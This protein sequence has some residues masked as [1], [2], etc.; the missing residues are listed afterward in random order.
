M[1]SALIFCVAIPC[2]FMAMLVRSLEET[3]PHYPNYRGTSVYNGLGVVWFMWL[4]SLWAGAHL[5]VVTGSIQ[6]NWMSYLLPIFPLIA[7]TCIFGLLDDWV[8]DQNAKGFRGHIGSLFRG[9]L[10]TGGTKLLAIGFLSLFTMI[11]LYWGSWEHL[12]S[13]WA[14]IL[15]RITLGT[16]V[17]ALMANT[18]NL[19]DLRP[20]R[21]GKVYALSLVLC[22]LAVGL[23][24]II[25]LDWPDIVALA[26]VG[27]GPLL[28]VWRYDIGERGM[29]GDAG[30]NSKGAF[31]GYL[32][33]TAL[34]LPLL[35]GVT[36][37]LLVLNVAS[38]R[39]SFSE[40][41]EGN[42]ILKKLDG[43]GRKDIVE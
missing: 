28:A 31:L 26:L 12:T 15:L 14:G 1:I 35:I 19:F 9:V 27:L 38:E 13:D 8:G 7:G 17:I 6:P 36:V 41:I 18:V 24:G 43:L 32:L 34:P 22:L 30:A 21:A 20:G 29:L 3:A 25:V 4:L 16:C 33:A 23:G 39:F 37:A 11:S 10:T 2:I 40:I 5:L 42:R